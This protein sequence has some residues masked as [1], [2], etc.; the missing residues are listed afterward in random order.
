VLDEGKRT[1]SSEG[2]RFLLP[3]IRCVLPDGKPH[4]PHSTLGGEGVLY[5]GY[6]RNGFK[7]G[8]WA[9][10]GGPTTPSEPNVEL[11]DEGVGIGTWTVTTRDRIIVL[12]HRSETEI[13]VTEREGRRRVE[14]GSYVD[15]MRHGRWIFGEGRAERTVV[16][17]HGKTDGVASM[18]GFAE[19][20]AF[21]ERWHRCL[22][23]KRGGESYEMAFE[24]RVWLDTWPLLH[25]A[26]EIVNKGEPPTCVQRATAPDAFAGH[27][28][29]P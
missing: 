16:Y 28:C 3:T 22:Q 21:V 2:P 20:D 12:A 4:G 24:L 15:G 17:E 1:E 10:P 5:A 29:P 9:S 18:T 25:R 11:Y 6:Y 13:H 14:E 19:C 26:D 8:R 23:S 27:D 7:H